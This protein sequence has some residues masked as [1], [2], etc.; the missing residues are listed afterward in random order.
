M[1]KSISICFKV[2]D[3]FNN[4]HDFGGIGNVVNN[5]IHGLVSHRTFIKSCTAYG[6]CINAVHLL[7]ELGHGEILFSF[8]T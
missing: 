3:R 6:G 7:F 8:G 2:V 4:L 5:V 1:E